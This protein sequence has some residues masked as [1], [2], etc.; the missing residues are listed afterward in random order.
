MTRPLLYFLPGAGHL[1]RPLTQALDAEIGEIAFHRF[2]DEESYV[3]FLTDPAHKHIAL[4]DCLDRPDP[5]LIPLIFA[6]RTASDLG[7]RSVGLI[8]PYMPYFR[9]DAAFNDGESISAR[10]IGSLLSA[11]FSWVT[12]LD[13][14]LHRL[15]SLNDVFSIRAELAHAT[16][17]MAG[18]ISRHIE[19]PILYGPDEESAQWVRAIAEACSAPYDVFRKTRLGDTSVRIDVPRE[20]NHGTHTPVIVDDIISSGM[21][22]VT[23]IRA[24]REAGNARPVCCAVHGLFADDAYEQLIAAGAAKVVTTNAIPHKTNDIDISGP[25]ANAVVRASADCGAFRLA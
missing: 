15:N 7:A 4:V 12:T 24:L 11:S 6:A 20:M 8:A 5:K 22:L 17:P 9:Q 25:L 3:R 18:W 10:H 19:S 13:A 2:P 21:T 14:H 23:L 1:A 16:V